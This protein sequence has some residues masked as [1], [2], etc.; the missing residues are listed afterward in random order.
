MV[1]LRVGRTRGGGIVAVELGVF[2]VAVL[3]PVV[4]ACDAGVEVDGS[5]GGAGLADDNDERPSRTHQSLQRSR[6]GST[7]LRRRNR[8]DGVLPCVST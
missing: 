6:G 3:S 4:Q 8:T 5:A 2:V 7:C 1:H